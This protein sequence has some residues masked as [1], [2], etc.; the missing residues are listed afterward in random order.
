MNTIKR[1][2]AAFMAM[3]LFV[4]SFTSDVSAMTVLN[5][6]S[7][8]T[9][10]EAHEQQPEAAPET[11]HS[12]EADA[13]P[14]EPSAN[15]QPQA[16]DLTKEADLI[17]WNITEWKYEN[18]EHS[19]IAAAV[20]SEQK[21][22]DLTD[23]EELL[24]QNETVSMNF[25]VNY[26]LHETAGDQ[27][28]NS[29]DYVTMTFPEFMKD[30]QIK[31]ETTDELSIE[32]KQE[33]ASAE[34]TAEISFK[35]VTDETANGTFLVAFQMDQ[36]A[37][38]HTDEDGFLSY[39][40]L[41]TGNENDAY[42][43]SMLSESK[44]GETAGE[45]ITPTLNEPEGT[46]EGG[47]E[48]TEGQTGTIP[49][50]VEAAITLEYEQSKWDEVVRPLKFDSK[51]SKLVIKAI[52][53]D[54][55]NQVYKRQPDDHNNE[56]KFSITYRENGGASLYVSN[57]PTMINVDGT[58]KR[59]TKFEF[60]IEYEAGKYTFYKQTTPLTIS[61]NDGTKYMGTLKETLDETKMKP[62]Q[63]S[64][65]TIPESSV[66]SFTVT[67]HYRY[68]GRSTTIKETIQKGAPTTVNVPVGVEAYYTTEN[69][70][71]F[72]FDRYLIITHDQN[73]PEIKTPIGDQSK[74]EDAKVT[75][76]GDTEEQ[77]HYGFQYINQ[78]AE[79]PFTVTW[80]DNN[81]SN[82]PAVDDT[83]FPLEYSVDN[84]ATWKQLN[85]QDAYTEVGLTS[86]PT[87]DTSGAVNG[88]YVYRNLKAMKAD[89]T[90]IQYRIAYKDFKE[91][92]QGKN[93]YEKTVTDTGVTYTQITDFHATI[94]WKDQNGVEGH[95]QRPSLERA[96]EDFP[97]Y[98]NLYRHIGITDY[99]LIPITTSLDDGQANPN[100]LTLARDPR[101]NLE[102]ETWIATVSTLP[103]YN[104]QNQ[105][106][107]YVLV[108]GSIAIVTDDQG[109]SVVQVNPVSTPG[110]RTFYNN[111]TGSH[112]NV[113][114]RAYDD[115]II[116]NVL[117]ET[118]EFHATKEWLDDGSQE[119][120]KQRPK[121]TVTLW[122]F[123]ARKVNN[124]LDMELNVD[125]FNRATQVV[126]Q[127]D[128]IPGSTGGSRSG[129][130]LVREID[131][132]NTDIQFSNF[133]RD[134]GGQAL[135]GI[136]ADYK[137]PH[138]DE[139][140]N[141]YVYFVRE[142]V[143]DTAT[144]EGMRAGYYEPTYYDASGNQNEYGALIG[145]TIKNR[146][147]AKE[148][149]TVTKTW[150]AP[151]Q[152]TDI[153]G[154]S[155]R[156]GIQATN[157][158]RT[159]TEILPIL[160]DQDQD[161]TVL[162][163]TETNPELT[164][165]TTINGFTASINSQSVTFYVD[166][167]DE[168]GLE[169]LFDEAK[170]FEYF[171]TD[172]SGTSTQ[173]N[174]TNEAPTEASPLRDEF[175]FKNHHY[176]ISSTPVVVVNDDGTPI[177]NNGT[178][179]YTLKNTISEIKNFTVTKDWSSVSNNYA[180]V[181]RIYY[182]VYQQIQGQPQE[183]VA[184]ENG[185][186]L[187]YL[188]AT[189]RTTNRTNRWSRTI[190]GIGESNAY[191]WEKYDEEGRPITYRAEE[192]GY[193]LTTDSEDAPMH[194]INDAPKRWSVIYDY[195]DE[196]TVM[197]NYNGSNPVYWFYFEKKWV[198]GQDVS[199]RKP[200][201]IK[202]Y[203]KRDLKDITDYDAFKNV[204]DTKAIV[205]FP[206]ITLNERNTWYRNVASL[207]DPK[208]V[209]ALEYS[210]DGKPVNYQSS[211]VNSN[212]AS[213]G[214]DWQD[215]VTLANDRSTY[216]EQ[217]YGDKKTIIAATDNRKYYVTASYHL[218]P[219][220][221]SESGSTE[222]GGATQID[223]RYDGHY[224]FTNTRIG[225]TH[226]Q[227]VKTWKD[228]DDTPHTR[229]DAVK[230]EF[231]RN[232]APLLDTDPLVTQNDH[233]QTENGKTYVVL[234]AA[235]VDTTSSNPN[236]WTYTIPNLDKF[237]QD[238]KLYSYTLEEVPT[239]LPYH[240]ENKTYSHTD[241]TDQIDEDLIS[242]G[243][244]N[245]RKG[246]VSKS[247]HIKWEDA[248]INP[249]DR[250]DAKLTLGRYTIG[251]NGTVIHRDANVTD[252]TDQVWTNVSRTDTTQYDY[253]VRVD[254]L[255]QYDEDGYEYVYYFV[256]SL[257][258]DGAITEGQYQ[259]HVDGTD[260]QGEDQTT[261][262]A[263]DGETIV[264]TITNVMTY[265][266]N[267]TWA[268]VKAG[269]QDTDLPSPIISLWRS[270][271]NGE[272]ELVASLWMNGDKKS[273]R[274]PDGINLNV[275]K[276]NLPAADKK[277]TAENYL[278]NVHN[279]FLETDEAKALYKAQLAS[280]KKLV[281]E[282]DGS[283]SLPKFNSE[284]KRYQYS[285]T[286]TFET[287]KLGFIYDYTNSGLLINRYASEHNN[288]T[289][290]VQKKWDRSN[291]SGIAA[292]DKYPAV[293]YHLY[294][295][296]QGQTPNFNGEAYDKKTVNASELQANAGTNYAEV[297]VFDQLPIYDVK[298]Q[299]YQ[300][301][302]VETGLG[303]KAQIDGYSVTYYDENGNPVSNSPNTTPAMSVTSD[304]GVTGT[305]STEAT[306]KLDNTYENNDK[307]DIS[308]SKNWADYGS[309]TAYGKRPER[310][311]VIIRRSTGSEA[312]QGN[313]I[314]ARDQIY[315]RTD[316]TQGQNLL[317][318]FYNNSSTETSDGPYITWQTTGANENS[319]KYTIY[320]LDR[321]APNGQPYVYSIEETGMENYTCN[322]VSTQGRQVVSPTGSNGHATIEMR[323]MINQYSGSFV[324]QKNWHDGDNKYNL[325]PGS[326]TV[327]LQWK[328]GDG[329]WSAIPWY[330][331]TSVEGSSIYSVPH[332]DNNTSVS[333]TLTPSMAIPYTESWRY[334]FKN[335][336][337]YYY[338]TNSPEPKE[339][340]YR[341]VE[342]KIGNLSVTQ[343]NN[344][345]ESAGA[346]T[347]TYT[348]QND[349]HT[350][351]IENTMNS[352]S[353]KVT[354]QWVGDSDDI[355]HSRP[356]HVTF[357]L[358]STSSAESPLTQDAWSNNEIWN[359]V[360]K[361]DST[362]NYTF[363]LQPDADGNWSA[364]L[365][366]LPIVD[367]NTNE[368]STM[369]LYFRAVEET[370]PKDGENHTENAQSY[371]Y[372]SP[373]TR[374]QYNFD[375]NTNEMTVTNTLVRSDVTTITAK[376]EWRNE[377]HNQAA[378][379]VTFELQYR[380]KTGG[381]ETE[382]VWGKWQSFKDVNGQSAPLRK[383]LTKEAQ[384][385]GTKEVSWE[386]MPKYS[387]DGKLLDYRIIEVD[388][389]GYQTEELTS[390]VS[391]DGTTKTQTFVNVELQKYTVQKDWDN[392]SY[393]AGV[394]TGNSKEFTAE[395][396]LQKKIGNGEWHVVENSSKILST[397]HSGSTVEAYWA[398][399][400]KYKIDADNGTATEIRYRAVETKINGIATNQNPDYTSTSVYRISDHNIRTTSNEHEIALGSNRTITTNRMIYGFVN[401]MKVGAYADASGIQYSNVS[402]ENSKLEN[403][404]FDIYKVT[405]NSSGQVTGLPGNS[406]RPYVS[407]IK[408]DR[409]G[410][411][412]HDNEGYYGTGANKR[413]LIAGTYLLKESSSGKDE[414]SP[415]ST[416]RY[417]TVGL[418]NPLSGNPTETGDRGT[419]W[420]YTK[421]TGNSLS[422]G[423]KYVPAEYANNNS[424]ARPITDLSDDER[425]A[426]NLES[427]GTVSF[428]KKDARSGATL[429]QDQRAGDAAVTAYFGV[430]TDQNC[431]EQIAGMKAASDNYAEMK[432]CNVDERNQT[433]SPVTKPNTGLPYARTDLTGTYLLSGTYYVKE[434]RAPAGYKL[435]STV[436]KLTIPKM[437]STVI[438]ENSYSSNKGTISDLNGNNSNQT[439]SWNNTANQV[440]IYKLDQF[441]RHVQLKDNTSYLE[442]KAING[443]FL[444][445]G[446]TIRLYQRTENTWT[447]EDGANYSENNPPT[448][449][450]KIEQGIGSWTIT[451]L[452][453]GDDTTTYTL[454]EPDESVPSQKYLKAIPFSFKIS[455]DGRLIPIENT[456]AQGMTNKAAAIAK[457]KQYDKNFYVTQTEQNVIVLRDVRRYADNLELTK[458]ETGTDG[459]ALNDI[460]FKLYQ[461]TGTKNDPVSKTVLPEGTTIKT[462]TIRGESGKIVLK[463]E[464][465][466]NQT[467]GGDL[468]D[469][470]ESGNYYLEEVETTKTNQYKRKRIYFEV[471]ANDGSTGASVVWEQ[472][473]SGGDIRNEKVEQ[474]T[475][476]L[477]KIFKNQS[478]ETPLSGAE[479]TLKY[480]YLSGIG[481]DQDYK[482]EI[483]CITGNDGVLYVKGADGQ[484]TNQ[485]PDISKKGV[486]TLTE[487]KAPDG[488]ITVSDNTGKATPL[489][490][491]TVDT[492]DKIV[493]PT[494]SNDYDRGNMIVEINDDQTPNIH[495]A[496]RTINGTE[497]NLKVQNRKT[498]A[499]IQKV[500]N[501]KNGTPV[502][503]RG[504]GDAL[505]GATLEIY[506]GVGTGG[507]KLNI[508]SAS[509]T[510]RIELPAGGLKE[511]QIYTLHEASA[512]TGYKKAE[513]IYFIL[514]GQLQQYMSSTSENSEISQIRVWNGIGTPSSGE[515]IDLSKWQL[516]QAWQ[517]ERWNPALT[518]VDEAII[519]PV[520]LKKMKVNDG[521]N[522]SKTA[523]SDVEFTVS[524][525]N[526]NGNAG[527]KL[528]TVVT[529]T[530]GALKWK[531][532]TDDGY[533]SKLL[534]DINGNQLTK[535]TLP[536][537]IIF[538]QN[539]HGYELRETKAP[540]DVYMNKVIKVKIT[541]NNYNEFR[542]STGTGFNTDKFINLAAVDSRTHE[543]A[544]LSSDYGTN[545]IDNP[546]FETTLQLF[547][548][549]SEVDVTTTTAYDQNGLNGVTFNLYK[550]GTNGEASGDPIGGSYT[551]RDVVF[552]G[553]TYHGFL[554]IPIYASGKYILIEDAPTG[555]LDPAKLSFEIQN[556]DYQKILTYD[557][558]NTA[559]S[560]KVIADG[561]VP[562]KSNRAKTILAGDLEKLY[563]IQNKR[564]HGTLKVKKQDNLSNE[565]LNGVTYT[566]KKES[567]NGTETWF[568]Q[569]MSVDLKTGEQYKKLATI[570]QVD[571]AKSPNSAIQNDG[572]LE[573]KDLQWGTYT[574]TEK[575]A[576]D[577]YVKDTTTYRFTIDAT[578]V[579][580]TIGS[581]NNILKN[582]KTHLIVKKQT[583]E[584]TPL[585]GAEFQLYP[586]QG[587][588]ISAPPTEFYAD[589][590]VTTKTST[591]TTDAQ[592]IG[593][594]YGIKVGTY[595]LREV[596]APNGYELA[597]EPEHRQIKIEVKADGSIGEVG[598]D[599][600]PL[601]TL[602]Q[603]TKTVT[604][605]NET[606]QLEIGKYDRDSKQTLAAV[607]M[608]LSK[609]N[610][611]AFVAVPKAKVADGG[612]QLA[613]D[614]SWTTSEDHVQ[615]FTD[616]EAGRYKL[617]ELAVPEQYNIAATLNGSKKPNGRDLKSGVLYFDI[618]TNGLI[619]P[620]EES[621]SAG[622]LKTAVER[623]PITSESD[624]R[625]GG[626]KLVIKG[627][628]FEIQNPADGALG[629]AVID[630]F[631][632]KHTDLKLIKTNDEGTEHLTGVKFTLEAQLDTNSFG[633][634]DLNG[635][636]S[637]EKRAELSSNIDGV[638]GTGVKKITVTN[639]KTKAMIET[640]ADGALIHNLPDGIY[641]LTEV[642]TIAGYQLL[643][644]PLIVTIDRNGGCSWNVENGTTPQTGAFTT[645]QGVNTFTI[646]VTN[647]KAFEL[648]KTGV[649]EP[650][651]PYGIL[652]SVAGV[653]LLALLAYFKKRRKKES[654][655]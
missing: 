507:T 341:A 41:D 411:L 282:A 179:S 476:N 569:G 453:D 352:T 343:D 130:P 548:Y 479:F 156:V 155:V 42:T 614:G 374:W 253:T 191:H 610:G 138:Y 576:L 149:I 612:I 141:P 169:Y 373:F 241:L 114:D 8:V 443:N 546:F 338:E 330:E 619:T 38:D 151:T 300:Y 228:G 54:E 279:Y 164:Q 538:M 170:I 540:S 572:I 72:E 363:D 94:Q 496:A 9:A 39:S 84:G 147:R 485:K 455:S 230:F 542:N 292:E 553:K 296:L 48:T 420:I 367:G 86:A 510:G 390:N 205:G 237:D 620:V 604:V 573:V 317:P 213:T 137:L 355:Y 51:N 23:A 361:K 249:K 59:V 5:A 220:R 58:N 535:P 445:G 47:N 302:V 427:R 364:T 345:V 298:G 627:T 188:M 537:E 498:T 287:Q 466:I 464:T 325:R 295:Y 32:T 575:T 265:S 245:K 649:S 277:F 519:A 523:L 227:A 268:G 55:T 178:Y 625:K 560:T 462:K 189:D 547:K 598:N 201:V 6:G 395:F 348:E 49:A 432:L 90:P 650:K 315:L 264:N 558:T 177:A 247:V 242:Y 544:N 310:I 396:V 221:Q 100:H 628:N 386:N 323:P 368:A 273:F 643:S 289:I 159:K 409:D 592:G 232:D 95:V 414:Y 630:V 399:L 333:Q 198:D 183:I 113:T 511:D 442:L 452:F 460:H 429:V 579:D 85:T 581:D 426:Y 383:T 334:E 578:N 653:E 208:D 11:E 76:S 163:D 87:I 431:T 487:T 73:N 416:G 171:V 134:N 482:E 46:G 446:N 599:S 365:E 339:I 251:Q 217:S 243:I 502:T 136:P 14:A 444:T 388:V 629:A 185:A 15:Q 261:H 66:G 495:G 16:Q 162:T 294:Q 266:G 60:D 124:T 497:L 417:F 297:A 139:H 281:P 484:P 88:K 370:V 652:F 233:I 107:A 654:R 96:S 580:A 371:K 331:Q 517:N 415:W 394:E 436:R 120:T 357:K 340:Q 131:G 467:T 529:K 527:Q 642:E 354:K 313:G 327:E 632:A 378:A 637:A 346:Y 36:T 571:F 274:F 524:E 549:D 288:R 65:Y 387:R 2:L 272:K 500:S 293:E 626:E 33:E 210:I 382:P 337:K 299:L 308:G 379:N 645:E 602:N 82:R 52:F 359:D 457:T 418:N 283:Y 26:Q 551:T 561:N 135:A 503:A 303:K 655:Q 101:P 192:V 492:N 193:K 118:T 309:D 328:K 634:V 27:S 616:L 590:T 260:I 121:S 584:G 172:K 22:V 480:Q 483:S 570:A 471:L 146:R 106:Y 99:E 441:G 638:E 235:D 117:T 89:K 71:D 501:L 312:N 428:T 585:S 291:I 305:I 29:G 62:V 541:E 506:E 342:T 229:P 384:L 267:K 423:V 115:G 562:A 68:E 116:T 410:Y 318:A 514:H 103:K 262:Q 119:T 465:Y 377:N 196:E 197:N 255:P 412:I 190:S 133:D 92:H 234:T 601:F 102:Y 392:E 290:K 13:L 623:S 63:L 349:T 636:G 488:Y 263:E 176:K 350:S 434:L 391:D 513:N 594:A 651:L 271:D 622:A 589:G 609:Q 583:S 10:S 362:E 166:R 435:D 644:A 110:Y 152:M 421:P 532:I 512:P 475:L 608:K 456:N 605:L 202:L 109:N 522:P 269:T 211:D 550:R 239:V 624:P 468:S 7:V 437:T 486:Y 165:A 557:S 238:G 568:K 40:L 181:E 240:Q 606:I 526:A 499:V 463:D 108:Q 79:V 157:H 372:E 563:A 132:N 123:S 44:V 122:R 4:L 320:N 344:G 186:E 223:S 564:K 35:D 528:G 219:Q 34:T 17:S 127:P 218:T 307:I 449:E 425:N 401:L 319:W 64:A 646:T 306:V 400:P 393:A 20:D 18:Q 98:M 174:E 158:N 214:Y 259:I 478:T 195:Y 50:T 199:M 30:V 74:P 515:I 490:T 413:K 154:S 403:A 129:V 472:S 491:F 520:N 566:L 615:K 284:G 597:L 167:Y 61:L 398:K 104:K 67:G 37:L 57:M 424:A 454:S 405:T 78:N 376:K 278:P 347:V 534:Y 148:Q 639:D 577:G 175:D 3:L 140:G 187:P 489:V 603:T 336:P 567:D 143:G 451:G 126:Y 244:T 555:Y 222:E 582:A 248:S 326:V 640:G 545:T 530:D 80:I 508:P 505:S 397:E 105:E 433:L 586:L 648:P 631:N 332:V 574:L 203:W 588:T 212:A 389:P 380:E 301:A 402:D 533:N 419:A 43:L 406:D 381:T 635:T 160:S 236:E 470:L 125:N 1:P 618:G 254:K 250:P 257:N 600:H 204:L 404:A 458:R 422:L 641:R 375:E 633:Y 285:V 19:E 91:K 366:D 430:Y 509:N 180:D 225:K 531:E 206:E 516:L 329:E 521:D 75:I 552:D 322:T 358:Q 593:H 474:K 311:N 543:A 559:T 324:V 596:T 93:D 270:V 21:T 385:S 539:E 69:A 314:S 97:N 450:Y 70:G 587:E 142:T 611:T 461:Y 525:L 112:G 224:T 494:Q 518:M 335:L 12:A 316:G 556:S 438:G 153:D 31:E 360:K 25:K 184:P 161:F 591:I 53:D 286:E 448:I 356:D 145:G 144:A 473:E 209:I 246:L 647:R 200:V 252:G 226:L 56:F 256:E 369:H 83:N 493:I 617:E 81:S 407:G 194:S 207:T 595:V 128:S 168:N 280:Q 150:A 554:S 231:K 258:K 24:S 275:P 173:I 469:G 304:P 276:T 447:L 536:N 408:T 351:E 440:V 45:G 353:L 111:G 477:K 621:G 216:S 504:D 321:Y 607:R 28:V 481:A 613:D 215:I 77:R 565:A 459:Q 439:Y 182:R